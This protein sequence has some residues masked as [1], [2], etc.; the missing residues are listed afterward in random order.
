MIRM[1]TMPQDALLRCLRLIGA[2]LI[3]KLKA[4]PH[5]GSTV[6]GQQSTVDRG[7]S[8]VERRVLSVVTPQPS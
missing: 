4:V 7:R 8:P 5:D 6:N 3:P 1:G 2:E